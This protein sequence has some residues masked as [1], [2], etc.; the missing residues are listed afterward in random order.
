MLF[1]FR[2]DIIYIR[3]KLI[4]NALQGEAKPEKMNIKNTVKRRKIR[5]LAKKA[6][7]EALKL[8]CMAFVLIALGVIGYAT[9]IN[10]DLIN[11][12]EPKV[13]YIKLAEAKE[14]EQDNTNELAEYIYLKE[15]SKGKNGLKKCLAIGKV[16]NIGYGVYGTNWTCFK[17]HAEE[18]SVL[19][20]WIK[21]K[22]N[23]GMTDK[24]L[25]CI[26]NTGTR[27]E[28]CKYAKSFNR[29]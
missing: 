10:Y 20:E 28:S 12:L 3:V 14:V 9:A 4:N 15:S 7:N 1:L 16:N 29:V 26:Y 13:V 5:L 22:K 24:E 8:S 17:D 19:N 11:W 27:T 23:K 6:K 21:E 18:M 2:C 25:L